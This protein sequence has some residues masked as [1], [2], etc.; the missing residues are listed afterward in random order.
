MQQM[1][2]RCFAHG[3]SRGFWTCCER[4]LP[5]VKARDAVALSVSLVAKVVSGTVIV[6]NPHGSD[7]SASLTCGQHRTAC[8]ASARIS[9]FSLSLHRSDQTV[10]PSRG[11]HTEVPPRKRIPQDA[12]L[13]VAIGGLQSAGDSVDGSLTSVVLPLAPLS[14]QLA[15][16]SR[17]SQ[18]LTEPDK[19]KGRSQQAAELKVERDL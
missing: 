9:L 7:T 8:K 15:V 3:K 12:L 14:G 13:W 17:N 2:H 16:G 4:Q 5:T 6:K 11:S 1:Q 10:L 19:R 18:W